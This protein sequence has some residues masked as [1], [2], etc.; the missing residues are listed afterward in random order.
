MLYRN[1]GDGT[2]TDIT[3]TAK[4]GDTGYGMGCVFGGLTN[5]DGNVDLYVTNYGENVL[6][7]NNGDSTFTDVTKS[8]AVGCP[9][10]EY[11]CCFCRLRWRQRFRPLCL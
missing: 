9:L 10:W 5:G 3:N 7:R 11:R 4:V 6:Y 1:N 8:A 2:F